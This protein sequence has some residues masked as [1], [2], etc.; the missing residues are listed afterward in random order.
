MCPLLLLLRDR[1]GQVKH[2]R[3]PRYRFGVLRATCVGGKKLW[4]GFRGALLL[5]ARFSAY[6]ALGARPIRE[7]FGGR[8]GLHEAS[9]GGC[10]GLCGALLV[11]GQ[12]ADVA[13]L[14][15]SLK[16]RFAY[17]PRLLLAEVVIVA[18]D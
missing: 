3:C 9:L 10:S 17:G 4:L 14:V 7:V 5:R 12:R 15:E 6:R 11:G 16:S 13:E 1:L 8:Y 18:F 2:L